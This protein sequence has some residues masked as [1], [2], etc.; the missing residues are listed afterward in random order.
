MK[1]QIRKRLVLNKETLHNLGSRELE[2]AVGGGPT[3][4]T[5]CCDPTSSSCTYETCKLCNVS[6]NCTQTT[7]LNC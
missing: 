4:G 7:C 6:E 1:K 3:V 2:F 5:S